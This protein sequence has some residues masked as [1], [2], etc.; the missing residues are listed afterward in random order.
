M[1]ERSLKNEDRNQLFNIN[2][3]QEIK[4]IEYLSALLIIFIQLDDRSVVLR[5]RKSKERKALQWPTKNEVR[6]FREIK[7]GKQEMSDITQKSVF[8][9][10]L[11]TKMKMVKLSLQTLK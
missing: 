8:M 1:Y 4:V 5:Q 9:T 11:F 2:D 10:P 3:F 6:I 7:S